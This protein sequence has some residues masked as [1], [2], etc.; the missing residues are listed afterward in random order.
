MIAILSAPELAGAHPM[1][2]SGWS[3]SMQRIR[4]DGGP[5]PC[6][7]CGGPS[8]LIYRCSKCGHNLCGD[9]RGTAG[10]QGVNR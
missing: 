2:P 3:R 6:D 7:A 1:L 9:S 4:Q 10:R 5:W 8:Y